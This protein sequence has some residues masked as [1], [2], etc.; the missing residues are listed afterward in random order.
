MGRIRLQALIALLAATAILA[1]IGYKAFSVTTVTVPIRGGTLTEGIAGNPYAV[2]PILG[3]ANPVDRDLAALIFTGLTRVNDRGEILPDLAE[4]WQISED[5]ITYTFYLRQDV[6]WHDGAPFTA[7]D[8]VYTIEAMQSPEFPGP[9]FLSDLWRTV[10]VKQVDRY[11]VQFILREPYAPF[12]DYTSVGIL[13]AHLLEGV[14]IASLRESRFNTHPIG[15]GPFRVDHVDAQRM[16]LVANPDFYRGHPYLDRIEVLF[17]PN[18]AS[19]VSARERGEIQSIARVPPE[20]LSQVRQDRE[21]SLYFAPISGYSVIFLNL[22]RPIFQDREV[23]QAILYALDRQKLVDDILDG[24]GIVIHSPILPQ[25]W[26]YDPR[27]PKYEHDL[28]KARL[29]L[30]RAGWADEDGDGVRERGE[31][32]LEFTLATNKD[33]PIRLQ[34]VQAISQQLAKVGIRAVPETVDWETLVSEQLRLRRYDAVLSGWQNLPPDPDPY[35]YW[36]SS[37]ANEDGLN[38]ANY[39]NQEADTLL[40][41]ARALH[42]REQR[43]ALYARFQELFAEDVP[44]ILLYQPVYIYAVDNSVQNV[45]IGMLYQSGDRFRTVC[46]WYVNTERMLFSQAREKGLPVKR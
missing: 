26:A 25:S 41:E 6:V 30:D 21:L 35:P 7:A 37:Q 43:R 14:P 34:L 39:V 12:L 27:V 20:L 36:H 3:Q 17:Y 23:R 2:N 1:V 28:R 29:A 19:L 31:Q 44:S 38:F 5:G 32:R 16:T 46:D 8:I 33:D 22:D 45:Q 9:A 40:A 42:D 24:Q 10:V 18:S 13:P 15:T 4:R 11:V